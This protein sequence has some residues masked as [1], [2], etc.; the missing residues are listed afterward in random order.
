MTSN[1]SLYADLCADFFT[2]LNQRF[3]EVFNLK[4]SFTEDNILPGDKFGIITLNSINPDRDK[5]YGSESRGTFQILSMRMDIIMKNGIATRIEGEAE[6]ARM[7]LNLHH[8]LPLMRQYFN[9]NELITDFKTDESFQGILSQAKRP[10]GTSADAKNTWVATV[11]CSAIA[12]ILIN[13]DV[14][15]LHIPRN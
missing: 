4:T 13:V 10:P 3:V 2:T 15:G 11:T 7:M 14:N 5:R 6:K 9:D 12:L 8:G 1:L